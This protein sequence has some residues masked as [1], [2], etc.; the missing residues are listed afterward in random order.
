MELSFFSKQA[1]T[2]PRFYPSLLI[3][4]L[5]ILFSSQNLFS[6]ILPGIPPVNN[7]SGGFHIEG[8]L[9]AN[10]PTVGK[11]DWLPGPSGAGGNVLSSTGAPLENSTTFHLTDAHTVSENNFSGG[12]KYYDNPNTWTWTTNSATAKCD[13]NNALFH[14]TTTGSGD[15]THIWLIMAADRRSNSGSAYIDFELYQKP[16]TDNPNGTFTSAGG[17]G[18]R[19]IG[20]MLLTLALTN[21]GGTAEFFVSRWETSGSG[22]NYIDK[23]NVVP[24]GSVFASTNA[25]AVPV[26]FSAFGSNQYSSNLFVEAAVDLTAL[27]GVID[28]CT[29]LGVKTLFIKTKTSPSPTATLVDFI[30]A[31]QVDLQLGGADA[32]PDQSLCSN[33]FSISGKATTIDNITSHSWSIVPGGGTATITNPADYNTSVTITSG[34]SVKVALAATT[35]KGCVLKDTVMLTLKAAPTVS[36][37]SPSICPGEQATL[38]ASNNAQNPTFSWSPGGAT[39]SFINV[40]PANTTQYTVTVTDGVSGCS[41]QA[42]GTVT[43]K[44]VPETPLVNVVNNCNGTSTLTV[45]NKTGTLAWSTGQ[46]DVNPITV[47]VAGTYTVTQTSNGCTSGSGSGIAAP[48]ATPATPTVTYN[49]PACDDP[50]FSVSIGNVTAGA[51]YAIRDKNGNTIPGVLPGS[52][53]TSPDGSD[54]S[55]TEIPAGSG[56]QVTVSLTNCP[57]AGASCGGTNRISQSSQLK[58]SVLPA[59]TVTAYPNPF[60]DRVRFRVESSAGGHASLDIYNVMGQK[61]K[62]PFQGIMQKGEV[63]TIDVYLPNAAQSNLMYI[64][65]IGNEKVSGKLLKL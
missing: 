7:P 35:F 60:T 36:V 15:N 43:I 17:Q 4:F 51:I 62:T 9:Q 18:G 65:R 54:F 6:Q 14:F 42:S 25:A 2:P 8:D 24:A 59:T 20:D 10:T 16:M 3:T 47:T 29:S 39:T 46:G 45:T 44:P 19:T 53:Y 12:K 58:A 55:F 13:I 48:R 40:T 41:T 37:N 50:N 5:V 57:A 21:G 61:V 33:T 22:Y 26:P 30:S 23:T 64:F 38:T 49:A 56:Y 32:G 1:I 34:T 63:R 28:P 27:L 31:Q 11:G 52:S